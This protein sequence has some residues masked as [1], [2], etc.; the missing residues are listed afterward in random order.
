MSDF[1]TYL[2]L[3]SADAVVVDEDVL[4]LD[5]AMDDTLVVEVDE[6]LE[7]LARVF[8]D[9]ALV[10]LAK[11]RHQFGNRAARHVLEEDG[12]LVGHVVS[13]GA[14]KGV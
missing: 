9:D 2:L 5:V 10:E 4:A 1:L 8:T 12:Q 13:L 7:H 14:L 6:A 3:H 11:A